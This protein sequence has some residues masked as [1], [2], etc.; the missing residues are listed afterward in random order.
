MKQTATAATPRRFRMRATSRAAANVERLDHFAGGVDAFGYGQ[1]VAPR[2]IRLDDILVGVPEVFLVGAPDLDDVAKALGRHHGGARQAARDQRV[3]R[4]RGAVR[5]QRDL[6]EVNP[7]LGNAAHDAVDR[8][9]RRRGLLDADEAGRLV[10]D[11]DVGEGAADINSH[12]KV[13]HDTTS[14]RTR[15]R[16]VDVGARARA[17]PDMGIRV[18]RTARSTGE[19]PR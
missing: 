13:L 18:P 2:H 8:I 11:T 12:A 15:A 7:G 19:F 10:H 9:A 14:F 5:E 3:G 17:H 1:P 16:H 4:D 6:G